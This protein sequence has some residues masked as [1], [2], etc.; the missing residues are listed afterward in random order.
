MRAF[1]FG[2]SEA[3]L[4]GCH[5]APPGG[6]PRRGA[7]VLCHPFGSEYL[8]AH[9]LM[10]ELAGRL[11]QAGFHVLRFDYSGTGDSAGESEDA[12]LPHWLDDIES[13]AEEARELSGSST[14][15][16]VGLRLG[17]SLAALWGSRGGEP[18]QVVLWGP[19]VSGADYLRELAEQHRA[20]FEVRPRPS[21]FALSDPPR[22]LLGAPLGAGLRQA[23]AD[24]DLQRL[25]R[26]PA[27]RVLVIGPHESGPLG[28]LRE[29]L[30][31][32]GCPPD[33]LD[34]LASSWTLGDFDQQP[35]PAQTLQGI[36]GWLTQTPA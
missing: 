8:R 22:E 35:V 1:H 16:L 33:S 7:L 11:A 28:A 4:F 23:I 31:G 9:R 21:D 27:R 13:A 26:C 18:R 6:A 34:Q 32:L 24:L 2:R 15:S 14:L 29:R 20:W 25:P 36:V 5:H 12:E 17:A 10:R 3:P 30:A 19:V